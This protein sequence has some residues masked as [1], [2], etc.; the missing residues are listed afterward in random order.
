MSFTTENYLKT[1]YQ[2]TERHPATPL[3]RL[4]ELA[5]ELGVTPGTIT[6]MIRGFDQK[7]LVIYKA[8]TGVK[9]TKKGR[10]QALQVV[11]RHRIIESFL[12]E[13]MKMDWAEVHEDAEA[14]EHVVSDNF[15]ARMDEMLGFPSTD[16]HGDPIP[17]STSELPTREHPPLCEVPPGAYKVQRVD[18]QE[19]VFLDWI[20]ENHLRPGQP[21]ELQKVDS[22]TGIFTLKVSE[23][24]APLLLS[25]DIAGRIRVHPVQDPQPRI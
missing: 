9:L 17:S 12:V 23:K 16:P 11:R 8:R 3:V 15:L 14:L 7:G 1:I 21:F 19:P 25:T 20:S 24:K 22:V 18:D 5:E 6:T 13:V 10:D 2:L 4:G